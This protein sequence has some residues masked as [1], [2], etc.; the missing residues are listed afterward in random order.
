MAESSPEKQRLSQPSTEELTQRE[1][2]LDI[3]EFVLEVGQFGLYQKLITFVYCLLILAPVY[4]TMVMAFVGFSPTWKCSKSGLLTGSCNM[5]EEITSDHVHF[6][7]RCNLN[8]SHWQFTKDTKFSIVTEFDL[9]C[10]MTPV[11]LFCSAAV[12]LGWAIGAI[13]LG[14]VSD[15]FGRK[16]V[17]FPSYAGILLIGFVSSFSPNIW[18]FMIMR[19][20][21]GF[22]LAGIVLNLFV[23]AAELVG[24]K[25]RAFAGTTIWFFFT[26]SLALVG[27][28]AYFI[29]DWRMLL[30]I[31]TAPYI[32][33]LVFWKFVPESLRWLRVN[34]KT[35]QAEQVL[36]KVAKYN[37]VPFP[38]GAKI[39]PA[40]KDMS[41]SSMADL[42][43]PRPMLIST[44]L[45]NF[46]WF[47]NGKYLIH[48][49]IDSIIYERGPLRGARN[50]A[51]TQVF[52][53]NHA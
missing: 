29:P 2:L 43:T 14:W 16:T 51:F 40:R 32:I 26:A 4:Q 12:Y 17:L 11:Y 20:I 6:D 52:C 23:L 1:R 24:P 49:N 42:F 38:P 19:L 9:V 15:R 30:K 37:K 25:Y 48:A 27:L 3:D 34:D 36:E 41:E 28:Q 46:I 10:S 5:T 33:L 21:I 50:P 53:T 45:Q 35:D 47:I 44:L 8:R 13:I 18:F 7:K 39:L 31:M 22:F